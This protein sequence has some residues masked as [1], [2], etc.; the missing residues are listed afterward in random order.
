MEIF[1]VM[2][3]ALSAIVAISLLRNAETSDEYIGKIWSLILGLLFVWATIFLL[4]LGIGYSSKTKNT[5]SKTNTEYYYD[6]HY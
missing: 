4:K 6:Y 5:Y 2:P 3:A 1:A